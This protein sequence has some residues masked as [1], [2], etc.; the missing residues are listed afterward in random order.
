MSNRNDNGHGSHRRDRQGAS[1]NLLAYYAQ[2]AIYGDQ[3]SSSTGPAEAQQYSSTPATSS[4]V[5][6]QPRPAP[7]QQGQLGGNTRSGGGYADTAPLTGDPQPFSGEYYDSAHQQ[8]REEY[9]RARESSSSS[10]DQ[11]R[12]HGRSYSKHGESTHHRH[13][14]ADRGSGEHHH[15]RHRGSQHGESQGGGPSHHEPRR[16]PEN[17][18]ADFPPP[19][20]QYQPNPWQNTTGSWPTNAPATAGYGGGGPRGYGDDVH[21]ERQSDPTAAFFPQGRLPS[22]QLERPRLAPLSS[23]PQQQQQHRWDQLPPMFPQPPELPPIETQPHSGGLPPLQ[24]ESRQPAPMQPPVPTRR[25]TELAEF[26]SRDSLD[27]FNVTWH[28]HIFDTDQEC[29]TRA[30]TPLQLRQARVVIASFATWDEVTQLGQEL[31]GQRAASSIAPV[32]KRNYG[33]QWGG[34]PPWREWTSDEDSILWEHRISPG[35]R[36]E[37][38]VRVA[39]RI[40]GEFPDRMLGEV[41]GRLKLFTRLGRHPVQ[42]GRTIGGFPKLGLKERN[43]ARQ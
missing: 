14:K 11:Q 40:H 25:G 26:P 9:K 18:G 7:Y 28:R 35:A 37:E 38:F 20:P 6:Q 27:P 10:G 32:V 41:V 3:Y 24:I 12:E 1:D 16:Q 2:Q 30:L 4:Y 33:N 23:L 21:I 5:I 29:R 39:P 8:T 43:R 19:A 22:I 36:T 17:R 34:L 31:P 42:V 15:S 13:K